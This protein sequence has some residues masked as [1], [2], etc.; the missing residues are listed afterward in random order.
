[1]TARIGDCWLEQLK[2]RPLGHVGGAFQPVSYRV[3]HR[4]NVGRVLALTVT[5][6][7]GGRGLPDRT[8]RHLEADWP[9]ALFE[10]NADRT[11]A[12]ARNSLTLMQRILIEGISG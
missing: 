2:V 3:Q 8:G 4:H 10:R 9:E 5:G 6:E 12:G 7:N 1:M 11:A